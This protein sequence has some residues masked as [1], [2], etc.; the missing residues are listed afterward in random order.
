MKMLLFF[1]P[2]ALSVHDLALTQE[3][4]KWSLESA[5]IVNENLSREEELPGAGI[6]GRLRFVLIEE[7]ETKVVYELW[8]R[9][10]LILTGKEVQHPFVYSRIEE[11]FELYS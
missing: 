1:L 6:D 10:K 5:T 4:Q 3:S 11:D 9:E 8:T 7:D 2:L